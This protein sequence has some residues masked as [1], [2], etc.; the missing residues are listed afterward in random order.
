MQRHIA[1]LFGCI[2]VRL[3]LA[4]LAASG[5]RVTLQTLAVFATFVTI[6]FLVLW[7][8][9]L[10][11]TGP[12]TG[13]APIWWD[14]LR[15]IHAALWAMVAWSSWSH[16]QHLAWRILLLDTVIGLTAFLV[17]HDFLKCSDCNSKC[18][19]ELQT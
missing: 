7:V 1:F 5:S 8:F 19:P 4:A 15:P 14:S 10:R 9:G 13:G 18:A 3:G 17:Y 16:R 6:G 12:E 2:P 11:K